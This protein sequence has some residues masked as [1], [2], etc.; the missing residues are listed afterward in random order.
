MNEEFHTV[1]ELFN[2][3][4]NVY[5]GMAQEHLPPTRPLSL[6]LDNVAHTHLESLAERWGYSKSG[7]AARLLEVSLNEIE[8]LERMNAEKQT[9]IEA[10]Q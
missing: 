5:P 4:E 8:L 3:H 2:I 7:L 6:R 10:S 9:T 1:Q